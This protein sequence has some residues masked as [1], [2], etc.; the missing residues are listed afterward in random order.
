MNMKR[1][2]LLLLGLL[3]LDAPAAQA[4]FT[5]TTNNGTITITGYY[6]PGGAVTIPSSADGLPVTTIGEGAFASN[7]SLTSITIPISV[8]SIED[9]AFAGCESLASITIPSGVT[10][11]GGAAFVD[12]TSLASVTIPNS[13]TYIGSNEFENC[14]SLTNVTIPNSVTS[15]EDSAF[16]YCTSLASLTIPNSVN[17]IGFFVFEDCASLKSVIFEGNFPF[18]GSYYPFNGDN[19]SNLTLY[20]FRGTT[21][22]GSNYEGFLTTELNAIAITANPT[23]G[24]VPL[25]VSFTSAGVDS[26]S[27]TISNWNWSF[28]D[29][30]TSTAQ[31]PSHTYTNGGTFS[32]ALI[33]AN[34][35]GVPIAGVGTTITVS[36]LTVAFAANPTNGLVPLT[37]SFTS[38]GVDSSGHTN[39]N[40]NWTFG[41]GSSSTN[42]YPS[43]TYTNSGTFS[44]T[45]VATNDIGDVVFGSG[46]VLITAIAVQAE[47]NFTTNNGTITITGYT[48]PGG[49]VSIPGTIDNLPVTAI[50]NGGQSVFYNTGATSVTIPGSVTS[51]EDY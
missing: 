15:I 40:W 16:A 9:W 32:P 48:G 21:G 8:T 44:P 3:L 42:Q 4:Q 37:V 24:F 2:L 28:G 36:P 18:T 19:T 34:S 20:Y 10:Y 17:G 47:F 11:I 50:G 14:T 6:G 46:T 33:A 23:N 26:A 49:A 13:I 1:T 5:F 39:S 43:H 27:Q 51:I 29:G 25:T 41:D 22:W 12:C 38:G 7:S 31:N 45:L 30:S 35:N